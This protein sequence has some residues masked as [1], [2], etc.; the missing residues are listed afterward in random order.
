MAHATCP[1]CGVTLSSPVNIGAPTTC[2]D[3]C[4]KLTCDPGAWTEPRNGNGRAGRAFEGVLATGRDAPLA[5]RRCFDEFAES[6]DDE[7]SYTASLLLSELV[8]NAVLHGP[9]NGESMIALRFAKEASVLR[10]DVSNEG[11]AFKPRPRRAGQD[12]GSGWGL[13]IVAELAANWGVDAGQRTN[14]WFELPL[15]RGAPVARVRRPVLA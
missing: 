11:N 2:P 10:V 5:A 12:A 9:A 7:D 4:A 8:T 6:L 15:R 13:H 1:N 14:V 3:C